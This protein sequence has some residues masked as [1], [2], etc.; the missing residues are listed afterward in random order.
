[1]GQPPNRRE[2]PTTRRRAAGWH[3]CLLIPLEHRVGRIQIMNDGEPRLKL[4]KF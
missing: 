3:E 4:L 1:M 2:L